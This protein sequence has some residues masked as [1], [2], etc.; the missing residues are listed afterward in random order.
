MVG[1]WLSTV[2]SLIDDKNLIVLSIFDKIRYINVENLRTDQQQKR[3]QEKNLSL[4]HI[5]SYIQLDRCTNKWLYKSQF[6]LQCRAMAP[7]DKCIYMFTCLHICSTLILISIQKTSFF[8]CF[9]I[10]I[11]CTVVIYLGFSNLFCSVVYIFMCYLFVSFFFF[12]QK[13]VNVSCH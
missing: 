4:A 5:F 8:C 12:G 6:Y 2:I 7:S 3:N 1:W 9:K 13:Y 11:F 10:H